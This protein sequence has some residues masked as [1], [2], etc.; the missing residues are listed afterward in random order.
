MRA[1]SLVVLLA[2]LPSLAQGE[3]WPGEQRRFHLGLGLRG[4]GGAMFQ[5][6]ATFLLLQSQAYVVGELRVGQHHAVRL[7]LAANA[8][9][10]GAFEGETNLS[11][12]FGLTPRVM[13]GVGVFGVWG[14]F[15]L[16]GGVEVPLALRFGGRRAHE[17]S[18]ALRVSPGAFNNVTFVWWDFRAQAFALSVEG[19]L[20]YAFFF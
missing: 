9:W 16:R 2:S 18:L 6:G 17:L 1:L 12:R 13:L 15:S 7:Q 19:A 3:A 14:L 8:G 20:G 4:V 11:F 10:P 5:R